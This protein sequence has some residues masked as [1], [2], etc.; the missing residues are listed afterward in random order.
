MKLN[1]TFLQ[2]FYLRVSYQITSISETDIRPEITTTYAEWESKVENPSKYKS[3]QSNWKVFSS[4]PLIGCNQGKCMLCR[5]STKCLMA[6][7][8]K[9]VWFSFSRIPI[10]KKAIST[11]RRERILFHKLRHNS[12]NMEMTLTSFTYFLPSKYRLSNCCIN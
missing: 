8:L 3:Q 1:T 4:L 11:K 12:S 5:G 7:C 10:H 6:Q 2:I 9:D